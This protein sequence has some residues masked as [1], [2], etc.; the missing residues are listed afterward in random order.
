MLSDL[1]LNFC[2]SAYNRPS[3]YKVTVLVLLIVKSESS[4]MNVSSVPEVGVVVTV[5][6]RVYS[7]VPA[8]LKV[9]CPPTLGMVSVVLSAIPV[10]S[11]ICVVLVNGCFMVTIRLSVSY[12][13][14]LMF[15]VSV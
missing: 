8:G 2:P 6:V 15:I 13:A 12:A 5:A 11:V 3:K 7:P 14:P 4:T 9:I 1:V 10:D